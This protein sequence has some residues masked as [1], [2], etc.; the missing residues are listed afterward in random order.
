MVVL[1]TLSD[2]LRDLVCYLFPNPPKF[3]GIVYNEKSYILG[4]PV[5][6]MLTGKGFFLLLSTK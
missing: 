5:E 6:V 2:V 4:H 3:K 1:S